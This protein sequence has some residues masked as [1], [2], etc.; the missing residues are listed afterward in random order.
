MASVLYSGEEQQAPLL[1][2]GLSGIFRWGG[3]APAAVP[4]GVEEDGQLAQ[5]RHRRTHA[6]MHA[7][8]PPHHHHALQEKVQR[9]L[10]QRV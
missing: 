7:C 5:T 8:V 9:G 4:G 1:T 6:P 3:A 2:R 10:S